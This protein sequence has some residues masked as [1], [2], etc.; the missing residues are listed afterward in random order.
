MEMLSNAKNFLQESVKDAFVSKHSDEEFVLHEHQEGEMM[1]HV[2]LDEK[3]IELKKIIEEMRQFKM[4]ILLLRD[5][6]RKLGIMINEFSEQSVAVANDLSE[7]GVR[8]IAPEEKLADVEALDVVAHAVD[9]MAVEFK[10]NRLAKVMTLFEEWISAI[11]AL[12]LNCERLMK[13]RFRILGLK[14]RLT[15]LEER[16]EENDEITIGIFKGIHDELDKA[17]KKF[18]MTEDSVLHGEMLLCKDRR[19]IN[20]IA[21]SLLNWKMEFFASSL[22]VCQ[23]WSK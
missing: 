20:T 17:E 14:Q 19:T 1:P 23:T 21:A 6:T 8:H 4:E 12:L 18:A 11:D 9:R 10:N 7:L 13:E 15:A 3:V 16:R 22:E 2:D 5:H